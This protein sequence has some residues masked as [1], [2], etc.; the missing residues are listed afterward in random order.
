MKSS[1]AI[2][3]VKIPL[4]MFVIAISTSTLAVAQNA[5]NQNSQL[6]TSQQ[7]DLK[8]QQTAERNPNDQQSRNATDPVAADTDCIDV[9]SGATANAS[10]EES[11]GE[12]AQRSPETIA[13]LQR[14]RD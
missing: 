13:Q 7:Q 10:T 4:L 5:D 8:D 9:D 12:N 11:R 2:S 3:N 1:N 14:E 6:G